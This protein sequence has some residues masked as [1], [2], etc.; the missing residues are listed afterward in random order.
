GIAKAFAGNSIDG[1]V[2]KYRV[3]RMARFPYPWRFSRGWWPV[4]APLQVTHGETTTDVE[5]KFTVSFAAI[6]DKTLSQEHDP[7]FDYVV[8]ADVTDGSGE[9]R[10]ARQTV[11]AGY[12]AIALKVTLPE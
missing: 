12:K 3:E 6:P 10:S 2:V 7:V 8:Y 11:S 4:S 5:G 9:T 1:A